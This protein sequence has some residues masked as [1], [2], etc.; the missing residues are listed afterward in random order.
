MTLSED[1]RYYQPYGDPVIRCL[2]CDEKGLYASA[3]LVVMTGPSE[4]L[5]HMFP[6]TATDSATIEGYWP[7][8][9]CPCTMCRN[10]YG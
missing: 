1:C 4:S 10:I 3:C 8:C 9:I 2:A 5:S 6:F 7:S